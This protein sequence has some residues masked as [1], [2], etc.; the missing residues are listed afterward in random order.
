MP[1]HVIDLDGKTFSR[2]T[3][4]ARAGFAPNG[5]AT[6]RCHCI[7]GT[8]GVVVQGANLRSGNTTS[9]GCHRLEV[10]RSKS[11]THGHT[12]NYRRTPEYRTWAGMIGRCHS[13]KHTKFK[14]YGGKGRGVFG[15]WRKFE[16]FNAYLREHLGAKPAGMVLS[17][18]DKRIGYRPGN[19]RWAKESG[20]PR[21]RPT[22]GEAANPMT[23]TAAN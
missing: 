17:R 4:V 9:C 16:N 21:A 19:I 7:C 10:L 15:P 23:T 3:V 6:W 18:I 20:R 5:E 13:P 22:S 12:K 1:R 14:F 8:T 11:T 2:L